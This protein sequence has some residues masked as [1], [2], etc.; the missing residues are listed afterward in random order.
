[1]NY[2]SNLSGPLRD[3]LDIVVSLSG[4]SAVLNAEG[5]ETSAVIAERVA[6]ARERM[7][8]R[9]ASDGLDVLI[10]GAVPAS[11]L[12]RHRPA[13]E[14]AMVM[15]AAYLAEGEL[16]Q[17]GVD[18]VLRLAWTLADLEG[19]LRPDLDHVSRALDLR[20]AG[21]IERLAA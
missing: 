8:Q 13:A 19:A 7:A 21:T 11:Y 4:Q 1:M 15:L 12:R 10:N 14:S 9:W 18:R 2:L 6:M 20:G 17:R 5:E 3:R 16:S